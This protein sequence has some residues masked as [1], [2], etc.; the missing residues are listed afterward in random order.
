MP[1]TLT[2]AEIHTRLSKPDTA[3]ELHREAL[4][5]G[6]PLSRY[7]E[8][9]DPSPEDSRLDAFQRQMKEAGIITRSD[10]RAGRWTSEAN[11]F[12]NTPVGRALYPEF[13][14]REW[15]SIVFATPQQRAILLSSDAILGSVERPFNDA[16]PFWNN[17]FAPAIP[18]TEIVAMTTAITGE[19]YRSLYMTYDEEALRLFRV[20]ESAEI[21]MATLATS[22]RS[23]RLKKYGRGLRVTYE[24]MRRMRVDKLAWWIRWQAVQSEIDKLAAALSIL[25]SGDGNAGTAA[26]EHNLL[27][28]DPTAVANELSLIG[29]LKFRM[30]FEPPYVMTTVL[31]QID[32]IIQIIQLNLGTANVPLL[33]YDWAGMGNN[34]VP[35]N[36]TAD[37]VRYGW[38]DEA[39]NNKLV[40]F[41]R[42]ASLEMITEIG[43]EITETERY[44]TNQ[45]EVMVMTENNA[46][47]ILD[48]G[49][50]KV[51][52]LS[53]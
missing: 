31:A 4:Q 40:G 36:A 37:A 20:G 19:D 9:L 10:P 7:L 53:E 11:V 16:G 28:L 38:T 2:A 6:M 27:T 32:E 23:I 41:D 52:D 48:P 30:Q 8:V 12:F 3:I 22:Q 43:S 46:F 50:A 18:L 35:I 33:G 47:A 34:L 45:T 21:P 14:A 49:A 25:V 39:P 51:L 26:T 13:F 29:W 1:P 5:A 44:I 17:Q 24:A 42:R 15:R